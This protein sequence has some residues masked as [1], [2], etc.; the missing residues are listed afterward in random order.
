MPYFTLIQMC[1]TI[2]NRWLSRW[3]VSVSDI[4]SHAI[5]RQNGKSKWLNFTEI[6][7]L[8]LF[9]KKL[10]AKLLI[11]FPF[12]IE[13]P[14]GDMWWGTSCLNLPRDCTPTGITAAGCE[15]RDRVAVVFY[16]A[17]KML[18]RFLCWLRFHILVDVD[19]VQC[20]LL[21]KVCVY[22]T[23]CVLWTAVKRC[24]VRHVVVAPHARGH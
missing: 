4:H 21:T 3:T 18:K 20:F 10:L 13:T 17:I 1:C 5:E 15:R 11:F 12:P 9:S 24:E 19:N 22:I 8:K 16:V 7:T 23:I 6:C 2:T 14:R